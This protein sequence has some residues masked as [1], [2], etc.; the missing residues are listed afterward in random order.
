MDYDDNWETF[1][2]LQMLQQEVSTR[3]T[4]ER[5]RS[6]QGGTVLPPYTEAGVETH[7]FGPWFPFRTLCYRRVLWSSG[8]KPPV[9][10]PRRRSTPGGL[11]RRF[12]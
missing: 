3:K 1:L 11:V 2:I 5:R 10:G 4:K 7:T 8:Q 6:T 12:V 9:S